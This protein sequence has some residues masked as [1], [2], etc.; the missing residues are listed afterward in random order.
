MLPA[1]AASPPPA[2][3]SNDFPFFH[4]GPV[5][6]RTHGATNMCAAAAAT[7]AAAAAPPRASAPPGAVAVPAG[8]MARCT[9]WLCP[10]AWGQPQPRGLPACLRVPQDGR[11]G[12]PAL[13]TGMHGSS[14]LHCCYPCCRYIE[15]YSWIRSH[16][17]YW[18]RNGGRDHI[19]VSL[20]GGRGGAISGGGFCEAW[21]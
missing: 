17:P 3:V 5:A 7:A 12:F 20:W 4:S 14:S 13:P 18:D 9:M 11:T 21:G 10:S 6:G 19:V 8:C 2:A 16:Y 15:V 1:M